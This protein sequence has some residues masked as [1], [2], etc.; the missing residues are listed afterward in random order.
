MKKLLLI[1]A[2]AG[3]IVAVT[4]MASA[5]QVNLFEDNF[6]DNSI[7]Y[8]KWTADVSTSGYITE[9]GG[10]LHCN[11]Y[12]TSSGRHAWLISG[13]FNANDWSDISFSGQWSA[14]SYS[15][16]TAAMAITI[17]N[18]DNPT[19]YLQ[20]QYDRWNT[21]LYLEDSGTRLA[22]LSR[23]YPTTLTSFALNFTKTGWEYYEGGSLVQSFTSTSLAGA[24]K[25]YIRIGCYDFS[26]SLNQDFY[27]DNISVDADVIPEP[28][29]MMLLGSLATGLFG[30]AGLRRRFKK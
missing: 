22:N 6:N 26:S 17:F 20:A 28:G 18:A 5:Y 25:F 30:F 14:S 10:L 27:F 8:S 23:S 21:R 11:V 15:P 24:D 9:A 13:A 12:G 2:V 3:L 29:T 19:Q 1:C 16:H 4:N 7:D